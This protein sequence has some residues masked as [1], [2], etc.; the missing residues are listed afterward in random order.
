MTNVFKMAEI[1]VGAKKQREEAHGIIDS[2]TN[3]VMVAT[4]EIK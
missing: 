4:E 3:Q 2:E 1:V